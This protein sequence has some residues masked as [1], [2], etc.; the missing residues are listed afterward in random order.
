MATSNSQS[1]ASNH[2]TLQGTIHDT[3][4][5]RP[6]VGIAVQAA[7]AGHACNQEASE[8]MTPHATGQLVASN[9][10]QQQQQLQQQQPEQQQPEQPLWQA[11]T[12]EA[13]TPLC[14]A[15]VASNLSYRCQQLQQDLEAATLKLGAAEGTLSE[16]RTANKELS[17][18]PQVISTVVTI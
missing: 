12:V 18:L 14:C 2:D 15:E 13:G 1:S 7:K 8:G 9:W 4:G 6:F 10:Q 17:T 11:T 3:S 5:V 16:L